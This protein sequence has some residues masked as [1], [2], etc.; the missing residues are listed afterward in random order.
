VS[1][2]APVEAQRRRRRR[3]HAAAVR[4]RDHHF[5]ALPN[6]LPGFYDRM[7]G[8]RLLDE[9]GQFNGAYAFRDVRT[10]IR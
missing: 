9:R 6:P 7:G 5:A 4:G 8:E 2:P 10:L 1:S 3:D